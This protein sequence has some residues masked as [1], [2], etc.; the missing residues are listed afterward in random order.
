MY[1]TDEREREREK[2]HLCVY[3]STSFLP[4]GRSLEGDIIFRICIDR[5]IDG[6]NELGIMF[7]WSAVASFLRLGRKAKPCS[8]KDE[9]VRKPSVCSPTRVYDPLLTAPPASAKFV[10]F[11]HSPR[12]SHEN[13]ENQRSARN[14]GTGADVWIGFSY[15]STQKIVDRGKRETDFYHRIHDWTGPLY[16]SFPNTNL[17]FVTNTIYF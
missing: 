3:V 9:P 1:S 7:R 5:H 12:E 2:S 6:Y 15:T 4:S 16:S 10:R 8:A 13:R 17:Y 11:Q 14:R